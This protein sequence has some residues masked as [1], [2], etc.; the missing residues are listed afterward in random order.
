MELEELIL[1]RGV[2]LD[3]LARVHRRHRA[4]SRPAET[5]REGRVACRPEP[6]PIAEHSSC[7]VGLPAPSPREL[8]AAASGADSAPATLLLRPAPPGK[9]SGVVN[10][11]QRESRCRVLAV[12][13]VPGGARGMRRGGAAR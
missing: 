7:A 9:V 2:R 4:L 11:G 8:P 1:K 6:V 12:G 3:W 13:L 5:L 10:R